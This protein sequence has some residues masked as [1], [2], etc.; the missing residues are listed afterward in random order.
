MQVYA[1]FLVIKIQMFRMLM[2][3][4]N[5]FFIEFLTY[6]LF[7]NLQSFNNLLKQANFWKLTYRLLSKK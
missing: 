7:F 5:K 2:N 6:F 4:L 1:T 3:L